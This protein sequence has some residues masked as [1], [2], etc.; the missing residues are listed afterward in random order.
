MRKIVLRL[1]SALF[2]IIG[3]TIVQAQEVCTNPST[4]RLAVIPQIENKKVVQ[5][6]EVLI[7]TLKKE[8]NRNVRLVPVRSYSAVIEGLL[9]Q[10]IDLAELGPGSYAVAKQR[11]ADI[12]VFAALQNRMDASSPASYSSVL[13][14]QRSSDIQ[15]LEALQGASVSLVDP[16]S[17]SGGLVPRAFVQRQT[18]LPLE[19]WF[20]RV[21]FSGTHDSAIEAVLSGR[22]TA[23]FV[24]DTYIEH[25]DASGQLIKDSL[26]VLWRSKPIPVDPFVYQNSLCDPVK[27]GIERVFFERSKELQSFF[28]WRNKQGFVP[29]ST[30]DYEQLIP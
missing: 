21:V 29:I 5:H 10:S 22:V 16:V 12:T 20:S 24:A 1:L 11:G 25:K 26:R 2:F 28:A 6:Y 17:T 18:G 27:R 8:L 13:I 3:G 9:N 19:T 15:S 7:N 14:T 4:L 23:A 30:S